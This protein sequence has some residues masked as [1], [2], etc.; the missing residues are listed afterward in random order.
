MS[1]VTLKD[2]AGSTIYI[3]PDHVALV[4]AGSAGGVPSV[5]Q[6]AVVFSSGLTIGVKGSPDEVAALVD[7][8]LRVKIF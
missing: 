5:G 3:N 1:L 2:A 8:D 6:A 7:I 4:S